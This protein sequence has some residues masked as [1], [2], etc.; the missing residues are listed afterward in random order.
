M[1]VQYSMATCLVVLRVLQDL[2]DQQV[3]LVQLAHVLPFRQLAHVVLTA[4]VVL[5]VHV[6]QAV[7]VQCQE[8]HVVL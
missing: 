3:L 2:L 4:L 1:A 8:V 5:Q 6:V 7:L